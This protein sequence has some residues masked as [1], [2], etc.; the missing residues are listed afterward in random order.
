M[1]LIIIRPEPF[2][3]QLADAL[4][5]EGYVNT[6]CLPCVEIAALPFETETGDFSSAADIL[7]FTSRNAV[8]HG[9]S[10]IHSQTVAAIGLGTKTELER[11][12]LS[13]D[14]FPKQ[15]PF[16]SEALLALPKLANVATK[17]ISIIRGGEG[18][19][20]L[21][22]VLTNRGATVNC[23]DVYARTQP[24]YTTEALRAVFNDIGHSLAIC[25][26]EALLR[27][28]CFLAKKSQIDLSQLQLCVIS[29]KMV[30]LAKAVGFVKP[31]ILAKSP[32]NE[33]V[34]WTIQSRKP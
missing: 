17:K 29:P 10:L 8:I 4:K 1:K 30:E 23:V 21:S 15:A 12:Q 14:I 31:A 34:V 32:R 22:E 24:E 16:N 25:T 6:L 27:N 19:G 9:R 7:I 3:S 26:S 5:S 13:V 11:Y 18:R 33:D 20:L 2:A 28:L